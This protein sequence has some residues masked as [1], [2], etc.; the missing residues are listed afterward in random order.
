MTKTIGYLVMVGGAIALTIGVVLVVRS[1]AF[2]AILIGVGAIAAGA[3][4]Y[5]AK[6]QP[7][8][9]GVN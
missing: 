6:K 9:P 3:G 5:I 8:L 1:N 2:A 7:S 4:Y